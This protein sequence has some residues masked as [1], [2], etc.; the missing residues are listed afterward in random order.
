[1]RVAT[2]FHY[3]YSALAPPP[4]TRLAGAPS[5]LKFPRRRLLSTLVAI[6][7][8]TVAVLSP[9]FLLTV[10][11]MGFA[12]GSSVR[13]DGEAKVTTYVS[14]GELVTSLLPF[15]VRIVGTKRVDVATPGIG[16]SVNALPLH[17]VRDK[18]REDEDLFVTLEVLQ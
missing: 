16:A 3:F 6:W 9:P 13:L 8:D 15:D 10:R 17:V 18:A 4:P 11:G 5:I 12:R 2:Q 14:E 1:L 7:P